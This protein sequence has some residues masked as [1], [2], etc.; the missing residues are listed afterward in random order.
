MAL[1]FFHPSY[2]TPAFIKTLFGLLIPYFFI[3]F[4]FFLFQLSTTSSNLIPPVDSLQPLVKYSK[5]PTHTDN[6]LPPD[7]DYNEDI[8]L[9][10]RWNLRIKKLIGL[11][12][13]FQNEYTNI[14]MSSP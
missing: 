8:N 7:H 5:F 9:S 11:L 2:C 10:I 4:F 12:S 1:V 3:L 14:N 6:T 13:I